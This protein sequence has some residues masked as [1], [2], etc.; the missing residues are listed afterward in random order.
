MLQFAAAD[1][2]FVWAKTS[3]VNKSDSEENVQQEEMISNACRGVC[4]LMPT[5]ASSGGKHQQKKQLHIK[6]HIYKNIAIPPSKE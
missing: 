6:K 2:N 4:G 5:P 3:Y 1:L